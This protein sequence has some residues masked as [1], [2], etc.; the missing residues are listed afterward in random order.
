MHAPSGGEVIRTHRASF[1]ALALY[2]TPLGLLPTFTCTDSYC[3]QPTPYHEPCAAPPRAPRG[4]AAR[5]PREWSPVG[6]ASVRHPAIGRCTSRLLIGS[7]SWPVA[8]AV[9][10]K[11]L[12]I[13]VSATSA[14]QRRQHP[15]WCPTTLVSAS[16]SALVAISR[17]HLLVWWWLAHG[18]VEGQLVGAA[19]GQVH[20]LAAV[21]AHQ[22][23]GPRTAAKGLDD[24]LLLGRHLFTLPQLCSISTRC[25]GWPSTISQT[26][27]G[28]MPLGMSAGRSPRRS[29]R[30]LVLQPRSCVG[31]SIGFDL[32]EW[33]R[34]AILAITVAP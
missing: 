26:T 10:Y 32:N 29:H 20:P 14:P 2:L 6:R 28:A 18:E 15:S 22:V 12:W 27:W 13:A 25:A 9:A 33:V 21:W 23:G 19:I 5:I 30:I 3:A 16:L 31:C 24:L 11:V 7:A 34:T 17:S 8:A 1:T 4:K